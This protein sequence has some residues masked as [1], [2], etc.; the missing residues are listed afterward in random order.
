MTFDDIVDAICDDLNLTSTSA[1][2]RVGRK[3]NKH[4]RV[5]TSSVGVQVARP[6]VGIEATTTEGIQTL[7]FEGIERIDRIIYDGDGRVKP[8]VELSLDEIRNATPGTDRPTA[9]A[10]EWMGPGRVRVRFNNLPQDEFTFKADGLETAEELSGAQ[11]PQFSRDFHDILIDAVEADELQ[12]SEKALSDRKLA[13][14]AKRLTE[15][16]YFI[17]T[18]NA[19]RAPGQLASTGFGGGS[20]GAGSPGGI[21]YEQTGLITF[22]RGTSAPFT[23]SN[24]AAAVVTNLDADKVDGLHAS[25]IVD[26]AVAEAVPL[27]V[28]EALASVPSVS[29]IVDS[30]IAAAAAIQ[31][32]KISK[33]GSSLAD[34]TTRSAA[35][36]SS[37]TLPDARFPS[38]LP[39]ASGVNLTNLNASALASGT[40]GQARLGTGTGTVNKLLRG[41][42]TWGD[43]PGIT[44]DGASR[45]QQVAFAATQSA[46]SDVNTLDD[47]EEGDWTPTL[48]AATGSGITYSAQTGRYIKVGKLVTVTAAIA[49]SS[50][51]TASGALNLGGLPFTT[52]AN[53]SVLWYGGVQFWTS[54]TAL[55]SISIITLASSNAAALDRTT[56]AATTGATNLTAAELGASGILRF[57]FQYEAAN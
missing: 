9:Y 11:E 41:N 17:A 47:Y 33:T 19:L 32:S 49:V 16:R 18:K 31:W 34:L 36:L 13:S 35:D 44:T 38:T 22:N 40:V 6:V 57:T 7:T 55:I 25:E 56:A 8:L 14:A 28:A 30:Q 42:N 1:K 12:K 10:I 3:V 37:G 50:L 51:G 43:A 5:I 45:I 39:A 23:V 27:A 54:A 2:A 53:G 24:A 4:C 46:S 52:S 26:A 48:T 29:E 15:L 21:S 20:N